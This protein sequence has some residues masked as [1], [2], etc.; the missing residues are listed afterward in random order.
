MT[1]IAYADFP[2]SVWDGL[3]YQYDSILTDKDPSFFWKDKATKEI[4]AV[5]QFII[6]RGELF[7][8]FDTL[9]DPNSVVGVKIDS[10][11]LTYR[12]YVAGAGITIAH[13]DSTTTIAATGI[14]SKTILTNADAV[15]VTKGTPV[16]SFSNGTF[17]RGRANANTTIRVI[18]LAEI[19]IAAGV[20]GEVQTDG[21]LE[22]TTAQ[23]DLLTGG[24]GGLTVDT[25]YYLSETVIGGLKT[26]APTS[27]YVVPIGVA[28]STTQLKIN[29]TR[30]VL[31]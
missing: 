11:G 19:D 29:L 1:A 2:T 12:T 9:G 20:A 26:T 14:G 17:K 10:S 5:E 8:F 24:V 21:V 18:G 25:L 22:T 27:G 28:L 7:D 3:S 6:D 13:T 23:W 16:Y 4:Q 31:L 15:Q 30:S